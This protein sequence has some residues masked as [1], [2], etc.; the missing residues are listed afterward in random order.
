M[1][2]QACSS[3][4]TDTILNVFLTVFLYLRSNLGL[5]YLSR[6]HVESSM[7]AS[8]FIA[9][10]LHECVRQPLG[11][12]L[13]ALKEFFRANFGSVLQIKMQKKF[14]KKIL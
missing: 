7:Y 1:R 6:F 13:Y 2:E 11:C 8:K 12:A 4:R 3:V 5:A 9:V 10:A 14:L